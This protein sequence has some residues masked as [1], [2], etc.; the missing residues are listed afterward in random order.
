MR[1]C[2]SFRGRLSPKLRIRF[3]PTGVASGIR[4]C[5]TPAADPFA[6]PPG[7]FEGHDKKDRINR[8]VQDLEELTG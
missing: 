8:I 1:Y 7:V 4:F 2:C 3:D 5:Q 6:T